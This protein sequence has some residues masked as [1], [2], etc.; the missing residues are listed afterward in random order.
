MIN[1]AINYAQY[2]DVKRRK[3]QAS[4]L[5]ILEYNKPD[6]VNVISFNYPDENIHCPFMVSK[7]LKRDP[8]KDF[9]A[10][11]R[12]PY[13][14]EILDLCSETNCDILGYINSD[15]LIPSSFFDI[16][17]ES[18][19]AYLFSRVDIDEVTPRQLNEKKF[20]VIWN[21][22]PGCDGFFFK[23]EWWLDNRSKF[24][25]DLIIGEPK[26]DDYYM[27]LI[28]S[29]T[30]NYIFKRLVYHTYHET[31]WSALS[32]GGKH[33]TKIFEQLKRELGK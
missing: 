17:L 1:L 20:R 29:L 2:S 8:V 14:K 16:F 30:K 12:L 25:D 13:I 26:I 21:E 32:V 27:L 33:N 11:R 5:S 10:E 28:P 31:I 4:A 15:I 22:H 9:G 24:N 3:Y 19:D 7:S 23:K 6:N 18:K